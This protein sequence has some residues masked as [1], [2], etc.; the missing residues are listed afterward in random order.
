[1]CRELPPWRR[2]P[3]SSRALPK[4]KVSPR[5][6]LRVGRS[7]RSVLGAAGGSLARGSRHQRDGG[8]SPEERHQA[9]GGGRGGGAAE[10]PGRGRED[11]RHRDVGLDRGLHTVR[12]HAEARRA[13]EAAEGERC[14]GQPV[15]ARAHRSA[16][17]AGVLPARRRPRAFH[18]SLPADAQRPSSCRQQTDTTAC[19]NPLLGSKRSRTSTGYPPR[20][21]CASLDFWLRARTDFVPRVR[22]NTIS[23]WVW[24]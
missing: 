6:R 22:R 5:R 20:R 11:A 17:A 18:A 15:C 13:A 7:P 19:P 8:R 12:L 10:E 14:A 9:A 2:A 21:A 3:A 1:M 23:I 4:R 16:R 24:V